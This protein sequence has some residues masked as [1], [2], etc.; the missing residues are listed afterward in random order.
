[1]QILPHAIF[2]VIDSSMPLYLGHDIVIE[3]YGL[4]LQ[5]LWRVSILIEFETHHNFIKN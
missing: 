1:M 4:N 3:Q 5:S 2:Q